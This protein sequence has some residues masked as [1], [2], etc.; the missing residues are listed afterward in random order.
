[1][2]TATRKSARLEFRL[3]V[4]LKDRIERA[5]TVT[6]RSITEFAASAMGEV[7]KRVLAEHEGDIHVTL[8]S[9]DRDRFL[10]MLD[11]N[12]SANAALKAAAK[13]H[14]RRVSS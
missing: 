2:S 10:S 8:S 6:N 5:A 1:M 11:S 3:P 12:I 4:E 9:R 13:K 7:A 14:R